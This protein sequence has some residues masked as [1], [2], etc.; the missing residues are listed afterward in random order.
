[1]TV[2]VSDLDG[3][4]LGADGS[5]SAFSRRGIQTLLDR[6]VHFTVASARGV[7]AIRSVMDGLPLHLPVVSL[8]GGFVSDM[9]TCVHKRVVH[10]DNTIARELHALSRR[11][12]HHP[13]I[14]TTT[15]AGDRIYLPNKHNNH[16][17]RQFFEQ[18]QR[19][20]DPR[21][22]PTDDT[23]CGLDETV[24][25]VTVIARRDELQP[26]HDELM[27]SYEHVTH[28]HFFDDPYTPGWAWITMHSEAATKANGIGWLLQ[29]SALSD[30]DL[31]VFGDQINDVP[32]FHLADK[33]VAV[34]NA[35]PELR[36][37]ADEVIGHHDE[38][39]VVRYL[40]DVTA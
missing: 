38:D 39:A 37:I 1:M 8:N 22:R 28:S 11:H 17:V 18:R 9:A 5:L 23:A 29:D 4:L 6:D 16:A 20:S 12:G 40:L 31:V 14:S 19:E 34:S 2:Y 13:L 21:I 10:I 25:C 33:A 35:V 26:M 32:M 30:H 27:Q 15:G 3:T 7:H 36:S 24:C